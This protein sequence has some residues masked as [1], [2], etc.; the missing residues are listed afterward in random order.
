MISKQEAICRLCPASAMKEGR[1]CC[2]R[3]AYWDGK[4][5]KAERLDRKHDINCGH[6]KEE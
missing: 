3:R 6:Y 2:Y 1:L 4:P 5:G